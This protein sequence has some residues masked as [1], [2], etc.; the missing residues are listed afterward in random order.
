[1]TQICRVLPDVPAIDREFDYLVPDELAQRVRAGTIVRVELR[2][3]RVRGW[4]TETDVPAEPGHG[5]LKP[6]VKVS[7]DGP[8]QELMD[9]STWASWRWAGSRTAFLRAASPPNAVHSPAEPPVPP[10]PFPGARLRPARDSDV[11]ALVTQA[12][13]FDAAV[14]RWPPAGRMAELLR[15]LIAP[16]GSTIIVIPDVSRATALCEHLAAAGLPVVPFHGDETGFE[17][18]RA[19]VRAREGSSVVVGGRVALWA[20]VPDLAAVV[21]VDEADEALKE[22]RAPGWHARD[23]G[24]ERSRRAGAR[25]TAVTPAPTLELLS[26]A[27]NVVSP[28][29]GTERRG[30]QRIIV[31]DRREEPPGSGMFSHELVEYLR[32]AEGRVACVLNR[33]GRARLLACRACGEIVTCDTC[34]AASAED[35]AGLVCRVCG[36]SRPRLCARCGSTSLARLRPGISR[37][38][39]ELAAL[40]PRTDV[41]EVEAT[42]ADPIDAAAVIGTEAVLHRL[43]SASVVGFLDFDQELLAPR[44]RAAEQALWLIVR[45]LRLVAASARGTVV[46]QTR[47]ADHHVLEAALAGDPDAVSAVERD[48]RLAL[49]F[50]PFGALAHV[51]GATGAVETLAAGLE[52]REGIGFDGPVPGTGATV[53]G[54]IRAPGTATLCT[55]LAAALPAARAHGR[56][57]VDVDPLRI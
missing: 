44:Y 45:A 2:G 8:P 19:W 16:E 22:E 6:L 24:V 46:I 11:E 28:P 9:L 23:L 10:A 47:L 5:A 29:R 20:P 49:G 35:E 54:L 43:P 36:R 33:K 55:A 51:E 27:R 53:T 48:R 7:S 18:T 52:G 57:R 25:F 17:R 31:I 15:R 1:M 26:E 13:A 3:R 40:L 21:I 37:L 42:T 56:I 14:L 50:P 34:G 32:R 39:E 30:W 4:V 12:L 38:R 41:A